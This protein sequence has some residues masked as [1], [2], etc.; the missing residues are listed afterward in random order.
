MRKKIFEIIL[1]AKLDMQDCTFK[2]LI[3]VLFLLKHDIKVYNKYNANVEL[4]HL[5][6]YIGGLDV[7]GK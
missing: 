2:E 6:D 1:G 5:R 3:K 4:I 7:R